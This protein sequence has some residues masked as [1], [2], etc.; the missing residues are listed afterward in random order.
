MTFALNGNLRVQSKNLCAWQ[1]R[2]S[3]VESLRT[4]KTMNMLV[5]GQSPWLQGEDH[6]SGG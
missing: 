2:E 6:H 3:Q 4:P 5:P 1:T